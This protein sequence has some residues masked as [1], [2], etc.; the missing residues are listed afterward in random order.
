MRRSL[1][2]LLSLMAFTCATSPQKPGEPAPM[3]RAQYKGEVGESPVGVIPD[4]VL[5]DDARDKDV[6]VTIE[7]PTRNKA[8]PLLVFS[9]G[10]G[11]SNDAYVGLSSYW[12]SQG[13]V[14]I[15]VS[16]ADAGKMPKPGEDIWLS[17]SEADR[18]NRVRDVTFVLDSLDRLETEYPELKEKIDRAKI[19]IAGHSYGAYVAMLVG[20]V[21]TY[22]GGAS[23]ADPR[24]KAVVAMSPQGTSESRGLTSDSWKDVKIPMLFLTGTR[25]RGNDEQETPEWRREGFD[26]SPEGDKWLI[27]VENARHAT[28]VGRYEAFIEAASRELPFEPPPDRTDPLVTPVQRGGIRPGASAG[29][30]RERDLLVTIKSMSLAFWD[31]YLNN[32]AKGK[33][34][35][36]QAMTSGGVEV[37]RK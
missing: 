23:Y 7:Y 36:E 33:E 19:G 1:I 6:I 4:A 27:V 18:R 3:P 29:A 31:A 10:Y 14:V 5:H 37:K 20:G 21:K 8:N 13:M 11:G 32:D 12:A 24:V 25:D 22:P 9:P 34:A 28:F 2:V 15:R 16:H 35:L 26:L 17:Q 30:I